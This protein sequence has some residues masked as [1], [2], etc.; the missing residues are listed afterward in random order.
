MPSRYVDRRLTEKKKKNT[1]KK[2]G[3]LIPALNHSRPLT[4]T[5]RAKKKK[6]RLARKRS[7]TRLKNGERALSLILLN[8]LGISKLLVL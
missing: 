5:L 2:N 8:N 4:P 6:T 3:N 1:E 7:N